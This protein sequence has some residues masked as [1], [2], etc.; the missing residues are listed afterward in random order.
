MVA[1]LGI[2]LGATLYAARLGA[3]DVAAHTLTL[4]LAGVAYAVPAALLQAAMVRI[5]RAPTGVRIS[6]EQCRTVGA[7]GLS[8]SPVR[9]SASRSPPGGAACGKR[10]R[11]DPQAS[12]PREIATGLIVLFGWMELVVNPGQAAAG[13]LRGRKDIRTPMLFTLV[14]YWVVGGPLGL[15][16]CEARDLGITGVW[17]GLAAGTATTTALMFARLT[18]MLTADKETGRFPN[19]RSRQRR[20]RR[21][22]PSASR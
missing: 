5:A 14:G 17:I 10:L 15:W 19:P 9:G 7:L 18:R 1:E 13:L 2:F 8:P 11:R 4:R 16:L 12:P 6:R 22:R 3:A 21:A 20:F